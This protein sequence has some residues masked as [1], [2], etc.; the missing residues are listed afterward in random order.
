LF[1]VLKAAYDTIRGNKL[2]QALK[3][4]KTLQKLIR[5][6]NLTLKHARCRVK[7]RNNLLEQFELSVGLRQTNA[8]SCKHILM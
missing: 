7:I 2:L 4:F 6:V 3:E 8:L 5:L 1:V